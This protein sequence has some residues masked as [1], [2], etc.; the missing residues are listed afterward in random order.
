MS[1]VYETISS[2]IDEVTS[3]GSESIDFSEFV[4]GEINLGH[5]AAILR[6]TYTCRN[7][8]SGWFELL[9]AATAAFHKHGYDPQ[10]MLKGLYD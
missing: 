6:C 7:E 2:L 10:R 3:R 5:T 1:E 9:A 8:I 4:G